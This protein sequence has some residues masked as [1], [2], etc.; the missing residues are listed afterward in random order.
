MSHADFG[1]L[2]PLFDLA[3]TLTDSDDVEDMTMGL[4]EAHPSSEFAKDDQDL[5]GYWTS[6]VVTT[7]IVACLDHTVT[8]RDLVRR[9]RA[10]VTVNAPWTLLRGA[11]ESASTALWVMAPSLRATRRAH[12]LRVWHYDYTERQKWEDDTG[13]TPPT[14]GKSGRERAAEVVVLAKRLGIKPTQVTTSLSYADTVSAAADV[15]GWDRKEARARWRESSGFA[16]GRTWPQLSLTSPR[17]AEQIRGGYGVALTLDE[18]RLEPLA[19]L[20]HDLLNGALL[21]YAE[22][23]AA[24]S[25]PAGTAAP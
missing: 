19:R 11:I 8:L 2:L 12:T 18:A 13:R 15:V 9:E 25:E 5:D 16:H 6:G 14:S 4:G 24:P 3:G 17:D 1:F 7:G 23:S 22:L 21:R 20:T 10:T